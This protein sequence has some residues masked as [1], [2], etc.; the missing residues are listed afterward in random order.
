M[1]GATKLT[2]QLVADTRSILFNN[3]VYGVTV[4]DTRTMQARAGS[5]I[6][7]IGYLENP[8]D[9]AVVIAH[10]GNGTNTLTSRQLIRELFL[11]K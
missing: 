2:D 11:Y 1:N 8:D 3:L 6:D 4:V 7:I 5:Y 9:Y 10:S